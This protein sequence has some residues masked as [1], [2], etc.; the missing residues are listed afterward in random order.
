MN[1]LMRDFINRSVKQTMHPVS[2][3]FRLG[4]SKEVPNTGILHITPCVNFRTK[5]LIALITS[6]IEIR[7]VNIVIAEELPKFDNDSLGALK[8]MLNHKLSEFGWQIRVMSIKGMHIQT[9][10]KTTSFEIGATPVITFAD[11]PLQVTIERDTTAFEVP[12]R[13][14]V[15]SV[16]SPY[17]NPTMSLDSIFTFINSL[18]PNIYNLS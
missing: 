3:G 9:T 10:G 11:E 18:L 4:G 13:R 16:R 6:G 12:Y 17:F 7:L 2:E 1:M 5:S 15:F 14:T 8:V